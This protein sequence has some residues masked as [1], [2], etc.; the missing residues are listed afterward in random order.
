[1]TGPAGAAPGARPVVAVVG[2][3]IAGL[4]AAWELVGGIGGQKERPTVVVLEAGGR[5]GGKIESRSFA[6]RDVD[7]G[8]DAFVARRP[9]A[10]ERCR[11]LGL[12]D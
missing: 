4:A 1:M 7:L 9:E 5:V 12:E 2:G 11:E 6:G 3:G 8:P 10:L